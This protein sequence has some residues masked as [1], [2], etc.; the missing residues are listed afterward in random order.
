M[1][2][3]NELYQ[4]TFVMKDT[5]TENLMR[6]NFRYNYYYDGYV[7]RF[8]VWKD[9]KYTTL[10]CFFILHKNESDSSQIDKEVS[11]DVRD[12]HN[13]FYTPFYEY[14]QGYEE[15]IKRINE[16]V[17]RILDQIGASEKRVSRERSVNV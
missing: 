14:N 7:K 2:K 9:G 17:M 5:S 15:M 8:P 12:E 3:C 6:N 13:N 4:K 10:E 1:K 11:I 16:R